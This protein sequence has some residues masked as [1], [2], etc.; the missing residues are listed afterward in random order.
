M[1]KSTILLLVLI[2]ITSCSK[3]LSKEEVK[4]YTAKG[5]EIAKATQKNLGGNLTKKMKEGGV[6][7]AVPFCNEKAIPLTREMSEKYFVDVKRTSHRLR[8][9]HNKPTGEEVVILSDYNKLLAENK[10]IKPKVE[11]DK[12]GKIHFYAPIIIQKKCLA[13]HGN[14]GTDVTKKSDSIIKSYYPNDLATGFK[15]GDLRGIWSITFN[16]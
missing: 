2:L 15:E 1:K 13:C 6:K 7:E 4:S 11:L 16:E 12:D 3:S 5:M 9:E 8:N 14:I 10:Q